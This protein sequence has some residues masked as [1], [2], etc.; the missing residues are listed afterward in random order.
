MA[1]VLNCWEEATST[2]T[3]NNLVVTKPTSGS[4]SG[5]SP[6]NAA[7]GDILI[8]IVGSDDSSANAQWDD[9]S[10]KPTGFTLINE[11]GDATMDCHCAAFYKTVDG[12]EGANFTIPAQSADDMWAACILISGSPTFDLGGADS[13]QNQANASVPLSISDVTTSNY[14]CL[15]IFVAA[16]DGADDGGFTCSGTGW[17]ERSEIR[18]GTSS[19]NASG[20]WGTKS[21][22]SAG[23]SG[24]VTVYPALADGMVGLQFTLAPPQITYSLEGVTKDKD[25]TPLGNCECFLFK[26]NQD[27]TLTYV[28]HTQSDG[29]GNYSF[30]GIGDSD[31]QYL[32]YSFK[33]N[34]PHIMDVTDHVLQPIEE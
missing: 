5:D 29:S 24:V 21:N 8:I 10:Y 16:F 25:G 28:A 26:D 34:T 7:V 20:V 14:N 11:V 12:N 13:G 2:A 19:S 27:N 33:D 17:A 22:I 1:L 15:G 3:A 32:V 31:A 4:V 9:S 23:N 18:N 6:K 30:T